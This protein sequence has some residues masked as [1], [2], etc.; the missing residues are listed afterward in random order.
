MITRLVKM[1]FKLENIA[2]FASIFD[3]AKLK[4]E[5]MEGCINVELHQDIHQPEI[6]FTISKWESEKNLENYRNSTLFID[7]WRKVKP[8][9]KEKAEAWSL[10]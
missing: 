5:S 10:S 1:H 9:F 7:T 6:F 2:E 4:I 8:L 3:D